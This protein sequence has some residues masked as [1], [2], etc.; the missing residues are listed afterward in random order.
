M[1]V[2][3]PNKRLCC[4]FCGR[5]RGEAP[6]FIAAPVED[7]YIC[8]DCVERCSGLLDRYRRPAYGTILDNIPPPTEIDEL[9]SQ[10]VVGQERAR[11]ILSVA[12]YNH[13]KR[14][15][16]NLASVYGANGSTSRSDGSGSDGAVTDSND[17]GE[18]SNDSEA[19][20][21]EMQKANVMLIGPTGCGKTLLA[22]T[23]A[24]LLDVPFATADATSLTEAGYVGEDVE[25]ILVRLMQDADYDVARAEMGIIYI[26]EIDK[27]ARVS[28]G[29]HVIRDVSGEGVQQALLKLIEGGFKANVPPRGGRKHPQQ[30][31]IQVDTS[32]ILFIGG[33]AFE[34]LDRI[35]ESRV[36][37]KVLGFGADV[38][39]KD[40]KDLGRM[41][42]QVLP[43]D[44]HRFGFIPEFVGRMPV[45][46]TLN[47]LDRQGLIDV[48]TRPKNALVKQ[49]QKLFSSEG[50]SL[51]FTDGA[52]E[53]VADLA[54]ARRSGARGLCS[55]LEDV[56]LD[57]MYEVPVRDDITELV[58]TRPIV[59]AR[60][61]ESLLER[62]TASG[63]GA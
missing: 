9:L 52:L 13:F 37:E 58:I 20:T 48:L 53:E 4:S 54:L 19:G 44:L 5:R 28:Q 51:R 47:P 3:E 43:E 8:S 32:N 38:K 60:D 34:G 29:G 63:Q 25:S 1:L 31:M 27:I 16:N 15:A 57:L 22:R 45:V 35:I 49:Y 62:K 39:S 55:I 59:K 24:R 17:L 10:Y 6:K 36:T 42:S 40:E 26:D 11:K 56:L 61:S 33:G 23:L 50:V 2:S 7:V 18:G 41:L 30:E 12:V 46:A 21:V 14:V